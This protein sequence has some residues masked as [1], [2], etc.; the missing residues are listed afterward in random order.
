MLVSFSVKNYLSFDKRI[1]LSFV[2]DPY[3]KVTANQNIA[4]IAFGRPEANKNISLLK[5]IIIYGANASGKT[6]LLL[7]IR[8]F[9]NFIISCVQTHENEKTPFISF[10]LN[11][12][13]LSE[14]S[15]FEIKII[16]NQ[17]LYRYG[18]TANRKQV[19]EEWLFMADKGRERLVFTRDWNEEK[20]LYDWDIGNSGISFKKNIEQVRNN[21]LLLSTGSMLNVPMAK[22]LLAFF[23]KMK[24]CVAGNNGNIDDEDLFEISQYLKLADTGIE[25]IKLTKTFSEEEIVELTASLEKASIPNDAPE[26]KRQRSQETILERLKNEKLLSFLYRNSKNELVSIHEGLQSSGT[27]NFISIIS[28]FIKLKKTGGLLLCDEIDSSIHPQLAEVLL[29]LMNSLHNN[30]QFICTSHNTNLLASKH[31][32][33]DQ[34][35]LTQKSVNGSSDLFSISDYKGTRNDAKL[36]KQYLEGKFRGL[37]VLDSDEF[38]ELFNK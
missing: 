23:E 22:Q 15:E 2:A 6:N 13:S 24:F 4:K 36:E 11:P 25:E 33:R 18:F 9:M 28:E 27:L 3:D 20:H 1:V 5:S 37:P 10:L 32:R 31:L 17:C 7:A 16:L 14:P 26:E 38:I 29:V 8:N 21:S 30:M 19:I 12:E 34:I 35:Y